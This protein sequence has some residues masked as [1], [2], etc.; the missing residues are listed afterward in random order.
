M[1]R[2]DA[3]LLKQVFL[4]LI[5]NAAEACG[6]GGE[7]ILQTESTS[8]WVRVTFSDNGPGI[9]PE[10]V[11]H[12]FEPFYTTKATGMGVGLAISQRIIEAHR[13]K[14]EARNGYPRGA[15]FSI[16]LPL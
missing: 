11:P 4:N 6:P 9:H 13:G 5:K 2:A 15:Q 8:P 1:V 7:L 16:L 3:S 12:I 14:I 10:A